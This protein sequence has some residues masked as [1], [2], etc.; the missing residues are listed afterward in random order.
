MRNRQMGNK[1]IIRRLGWDLPVEWSS[2]LPPTAVL[3]RLK[4]RTSEAVWR[5]FF[6]LGLRKPFYGRLTECGGSITPVS[7][8]P[9]V[10]TGRSLEFTIEA[11]QSGSIV[12]GLLRLP[13]GLRVYVV[14]CLTLAICLEGVQLYWLFAA[15]APDYVGIARDL[16]QPFL[17]IPFI[18]CYVSV[19]LWWSR[20][21]ELQF[22]RTI[23]RLAEADPTERQMKM[24]PAAP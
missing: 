1:Q 19:G 11:S 17:V 12:R 20:K 4:E 2:P 7:G 21:Q 5:Q 9:S 3:D 18:W 10:Y 15:T 8:W 22:L 13:K 14:F 6:Q 16:L 23:E 24:Y